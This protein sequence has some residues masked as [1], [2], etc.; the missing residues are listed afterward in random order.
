MSKMIAASLPHPIIGQFTARSGSC[1]YGMFN[2]HGGV[3]DGPYASLNIGASLG[4][5]PEA[6][7]E[8]RRL[9]K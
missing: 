2:R 8:N 9:V 7:A 4:D 5:L 6:V 1:C 3:S